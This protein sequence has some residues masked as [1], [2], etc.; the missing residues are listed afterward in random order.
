MVGGLAANGLC[1][2]AALLAALCFPAGI[3]AF[4]CGIFAAVNALLGASN[5][6]PF[7][8]KVGRGML[9]SDGKILLKAIRT[10]SVTPLPPD[11]IQTA[12]GCRPLWHAIGDRRMDRLYTLC[13]ASS[14]LDLG[15]AARAEAL[16]AEAV[17]IDAPHLHIDWLEACLRANL[18]LARG[19]V[20]GARAALVEVER[21][22]DPA[23]LEG[24]YL[25][26]LLRAN[27][28]QIQGELTQAMAA[29]EALSLD[30]VGERCSDL[31]SSALA[32]QLRTACIAGDRDAVIAVRARYEVRRTQPSEVHNLHF[33]GLLA[34]F[35]T[36]RGDDA[37]DA[38]HRALQAIVVLAGPWRDPSD[39]ATFLEA[40]RTLIEEARLVLDVA[41]AAP[42]L[43]AIETHQP[44][45]VLMAWD[46]GYRRWSRCLMLINVV[47]SVPLVLLA[48]ALGRP[49]G[50]PAMFL[51]VLLAFF[52][53]LGVL[54]LLFDLAA[55]KLFPS[56][57]RLTG[58]ILLSL[59]AM[60]WV[61]GVLFG[62]SEIFNP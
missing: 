53:L 4:V 30:P 54:Y 7:D 27:L 20:A 6:L 38:Y 58:F 18:A 17:A 11:V 46:E 34:R 29:Y 62:F 22:T 8:M 52:T 61:G 35:A 45:S 56:L 23:A 1:A 32:A 13:A 48:S 10:R 59:A 55:G 21:L 50:G 26:D 43:S 31:V 16:F 41:S 42:L 15:S 25:L 19:E 51:A 9:R 2:A 39:K 24:R 49:Q 47:S 33:Y 5:L 28:L 37:R 14:W 44:D 60:P 57:K 36:G 12:T 3:P 40:Q